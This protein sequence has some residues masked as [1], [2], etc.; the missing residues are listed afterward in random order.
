VATLRSDGEHLVLTLRPLE[1][2]AA[3]H[4]DV[5]V[6]LAQVRSVRKVDPWSSLRG[7]RAP[8]TGIPHVVAYGTFRSR[9]GKD[10]AAVKGKGAA[11]LVELD[12]RKPFKRLLV[13]ATDAGRIATRLRLA[14]RVKG[15]F[16]SLVRLG[17]R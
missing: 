6:P 16:R 11:V 12:C 5:R 2:L 3:L 4:G 14:A 10:F 17:R 15:R 13:S 7:L 9:Q 1:K 8:G